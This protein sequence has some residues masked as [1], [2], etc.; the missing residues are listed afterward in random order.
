MDRILATL[1]SA[2][3]FASVLPEV[4]FSES[5][6]PVGTTWK[7]EQILIWSALRQNSLPANALALGRCGM[8]LP[9]SYLYCGYHC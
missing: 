5:I 2:V 8:K 3:L 1:G 9:T 6:P 7:H 4:A